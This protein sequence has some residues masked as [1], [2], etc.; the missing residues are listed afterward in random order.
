M[1]FLDLQELFKQEGENTVLY[2]LHFTMQEGERVAIAGETGSGKST[3]LKLIAGLLQP[4]GGNVYFEG[5][6]VLGPDEQ[7][8]PGHPKIAYLSQHYELRNNY[9]VHELLSMTNQLDYRSAQQ[10]F[11]VCRIAHLMMRRSDELSGGEKQR[12]AL[13]KQ[14]TSY[15]KL[16]LLDEPFSNLDRV[17]KALIRSVIEDIS[18]KLKVTCVLVSHDATDLLSWADRILIMQDGQLV[19]QGAPRQLYHHPVNEY[20][21]A[22]MGEY[23]LINTKTHE[24]FVQ[25]LGEGV[26]GKRALIRPEQLAISVSK[27]SNP[28]WVEGVVQKV[29]FFGAYYAIEVLVDGFTLKVNTPTFLFNPGDIVFVFVASNSTA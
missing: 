10:I 26:R 12:I 22:L 17:H 27:P 28:H 29:M 2:P 6:R 8:L 24:V 3:L 4:T 14:L 19:Q 23:N 16:L 20:V 21:A 25:M 5:M 11:E 9:K 15:P 7:L 1:V 18:D 13:A